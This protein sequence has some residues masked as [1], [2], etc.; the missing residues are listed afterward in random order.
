MFES[1]SEKI[2]KGIS[3]ALRCVGKNI[4]LPTLEYVL[5]IINKNTLT[6]R[7]TNLSIGTEVIIAIKSDSS[8]TLAIRGDILFSFLSN[9]IN[10]EK[11]VCEKRG[12][13]FIIKTKNST[14]TLKTFPYDDFPTLPRIESEE[15][16]TLPVTTFVDG[17]KAVLFSASLS[18]SKPEISSVYIYKEENNL[19][20]VSTD[21]FR[22]AEK[23]II[24]K[25]TIS[26]N[27]IIIPQK[28]AI[29]LVKIFENQ[30]GDVL[31][32]TS[33]NQC[34]FE[35]GGVYITTRLISGI[36]PDYAQIIPKQEETSIIVLRQDLLSS[37]KLSNTFSDKLNQAEFEVSDKQFIVSAKNSDVGE[38]VSNVDATVEGKPITVVVN[39]KYISDVFQSI[40]SDSISLS[41]F[42]TQKPIIFRGISDSSFMYLVMPMNR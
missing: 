33:E 28:N 11:I 38:Q 26:F 23:K 14:A 9:I 8:E 3:I 22:L 24:L 17:I 32:N 7:A 6:I 4:T 10:D 20:F 15:K 29:E 37:L 13:L 21:S 1:T 2:K 40:S 27:P 5:L 12:E 39:Q 41:F 34:S 35:C 19:V 18:E 16:N 36:F 30:N 42:G 31:V 25:K